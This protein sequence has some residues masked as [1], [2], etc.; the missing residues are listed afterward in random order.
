MTLIF[1]K[2]PIF[3]FQISLP[4]KLNN[5]EALNISSKETLLPPDSIAGGP[6]AEHW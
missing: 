2:E 3:P 6:S 4:I 1:L 5:M